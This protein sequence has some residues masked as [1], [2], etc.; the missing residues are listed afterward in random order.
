MQTSLIH[1][2][3]YQPMK[4]AMPDVDPIMVPDDAATT[5]INFVRDGNTIRIRDGVELFGTCQTGTSTERISGI[6]RLSNEDIDTIL[7]VVTDNAIYKYD[8]QTN[9]F[10]SLMPPGMSLSGNDIAQP[11]ARVFFKEDGSRLIFVNGV[12]TPKILDRNANTIRDMLGSP[13]EAECIA[14]SANRVLLSQGYTIYVSAFNDCDAGYQTEQIVVL[15]DTPG[16]IM[17]MLE[18]G[19]LSTIIFKE[20]AIYECIATGGPYPFEFRL[21]TAN[22]VGL[23]SSNSVVP[24]PDGNIL[25]LGRDGSV[26]LYDGVNI[27]FVSSAARAYLA[28]KLDRSK[29]FRAFGY[30]D[31]QLN[32]AVFFGPD[33]VDGYCKNGVALTF[34]EFYVFPLLLPFTVTVG[35]SIFVPSSPV[36]EDFDV[37]W[38]PDS[39]WE[40][41]GG[42]YIRTLFGTQDSKIFTATSA[43]DDGQPI[44]A[45]IV[46]KALPLADSTPFITVAGT[47]LFISGGPA[48]VKAQLYATD[49]G[50]SE[51]LY[52]EGPL[53]A[54]GAGPLSLGMRASCRTGYIRFVINAQGPLKYRGASIALAPRGQR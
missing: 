27:Q 6:F 44:Y 51:L 19:N 52:E 4:G 46:T 32:A 22:T 35:T 7:A 49:Y 24:L 54:A 38:G 28:S 11:Q 33:P 20:D 17:L 10:V 41:I 43:T 45:E 29:M 23:A 8:V 48:T 47:E 14:V 18:R 53:P 21:K 30:W 9:S 42:D 50:E 5:L 2:L 39:A 37:P 12:D 15:A 16:K 13:P 34:P 36:W 40:S 25:F 31:L 1:K 26:Y 3:F